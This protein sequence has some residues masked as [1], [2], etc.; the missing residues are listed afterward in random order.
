VSHSETQW[1]VDE[2]KPLPW[3]Q[4]IRMPWN[5]YRQVLLPTEIVP[6]T[7]PWGIVGNL[8]VLERRVQEM[9]NDA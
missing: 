7:E 6:P 9:K 1:T 5:R 2:I 8:D 3:W 4:R